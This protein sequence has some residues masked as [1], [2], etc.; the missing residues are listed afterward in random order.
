MKNILMEDLILAHYD[1]KKRTRFHIDHNLVGIWAVL[2]H[3][4]MRLKKEKVIGD[5]SFT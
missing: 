3:G 4:T 1:T 5:Q 2:A